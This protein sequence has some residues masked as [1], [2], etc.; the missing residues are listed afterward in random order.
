MKSYA[1][2][3]LIL[4]PLFVFFSFIKLSSVIKCGSTSKKL[5][6]YP[7]IPGEMAATHCTIE[8]IKEQQWAHSECFRDLSKIRYIQIDFGYAA[9]YH[10]GLEAKSPFT[11]TDE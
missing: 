4:Q 5:T 8:G 7:Y 10:K 3:H 6:S 1:L 2:K 11:V 9:F